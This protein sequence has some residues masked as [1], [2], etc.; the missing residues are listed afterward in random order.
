MQVSD[1]W[2]PFVMYRAT[3][4]QHE[5]TVRLASCGGGE[6]FFDEVAVQRVPPEILSQLPTGRPT[7]DSRRTGIGPPRIAR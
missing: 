4:V 5:W 6:V 2:Q 3:D 1:Q 7:L